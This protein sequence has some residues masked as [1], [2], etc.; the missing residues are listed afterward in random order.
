[1]TH[2]IVPVNSNQTHWLIVVLDLKMKQFVVIDSMRSYNI[3]MYLKEVT[4]LKSAFQSE[5][6]FGPTVNEWPVVICQT[7]P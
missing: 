7:N 1:M 2:L 4:T 3:N 5:K 6:L